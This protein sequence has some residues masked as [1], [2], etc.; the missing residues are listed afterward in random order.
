VIGEGWELLDGRVDGE[1]EAA[2]EEVLESYF[3]N[4]PFYTFQHINFK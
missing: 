2:V 3:Y 4:S 1:A